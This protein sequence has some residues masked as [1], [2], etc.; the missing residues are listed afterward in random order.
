MLNGPSDKIGSFYAFFYADVNIN[1][2][3]Y[4]IYNDL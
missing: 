1:N 2:L 3:R 4:E